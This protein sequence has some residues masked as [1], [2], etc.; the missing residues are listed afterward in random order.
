MLTPAQ[1]HWAR[2]MAERRGEPD[3]HQA[4]MTAYEQMLYRL[5][6]DQSRLKAVQS[7]T[8]RAEMK[9]T[10][11]PAYADWVEGVLS[12]DTGQ[13]DEVLTAVMIW[14]LDV[15][16]LAPALRIAEYVLRHQ[17]P[18][19]DQYRRTPATLVVDEICD[20]ALTAFAATSSP[21]IPVDPALLRQVVALTEGHDMPDEVRAKLLKTLAYTLRNR[22]ADGDSAEALSL[23]QQAL[24]LH[25]GIGVKRDIEVLDRQLK[26]AAE[27]TPASKTTK[28]T[29]AGRKRAAG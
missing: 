5:R 7:L 15:G 20:P 18:L 14:R 17:L 16:D 13:T 9:R 25:S 3:M 24:R 29:P 22:A 28:R 2:V 10:M 1:E 11:L 26:K 6:M 23:L 19:P 4:T 21:V 27:S 12:A 8:T